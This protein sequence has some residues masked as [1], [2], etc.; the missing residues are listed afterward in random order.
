[1]RSGAA[2]DAVGLRHAITGTSRRLSR[3]KEECLDIMYE[4]G[5]HALHLCALLRCP[6]VPHAVTK[7]CQ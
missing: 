2:C 6:G 3:T 5:R 7:S 1:M 4:G